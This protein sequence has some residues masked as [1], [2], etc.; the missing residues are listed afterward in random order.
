[1]LISLI[2]P[3][4]NEQGSIPALLL[5][6]D[7]AVEELSRAGHSVECITVDD[8]SRDG[9]AQLLKEATHQRGYLRV[10]CFSRNFGQTAAL[11]AG[12]AE[13]SGDVIVCMD[14]DLQNDPADIPQLVERLQDGYDVVSGWRK[15]RHDKTLSRILPSM[16]AN[17]LISWTT[18][19]RLHD[20]GCTLKAYRKEVM[21]GVR[22]YGEMHRLLPVYAAWQG[23]RVTELPVRH[24]PRRAGESKY[25]LS[26]VPNL[27]L[28]LLLVRL[29]WSYGQKPIH[30]FGKFGLGSLALSFLSFLGMLYFK[31][32]GDKSFIQTPLPQLTVTFFLIGCLSILIGFLAEIT[33]RTYHEATG[34]PTYVI[35]Q[36][37]PEGRF[38]SATS[39]TSRHVREA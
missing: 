39:P 26:R 30:L 14:A 10:V 38:R 34:S 28:D 2:V 8:G 7:D 6:L 5:A 9:S 21:Q 27:V 16:L 18:G 17:R 29:L 19:V 32:W 25:S 12:F 24:H 4:F 11:S 35:R 23:A 20:H 36:R 22:L 37:I 31:F 33:V 15:E 13:A 3:C 1:M